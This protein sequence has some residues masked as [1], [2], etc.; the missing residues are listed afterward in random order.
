MTDFNSPVSSSSRTLE[1]LIADALEHLEQLGYSRRVYR[2]YNC[3]WKKFLCFSLT[4]D[5]DRFSS[6][7]VQSFLAD[8]GVPVEKPDIPLPQVKRYYRTAMRV[9]T[10]FHLHGCFQRRMGLAPKF[11]LSMHNEEIL[12]SYLNFC[13]DT[14][15]ISP[16]A[17]RGRKRNVTMFL[18]FL[19]TH[20]IASVGDIQPE[21]LSKFMVSQCHLVPRTLSG[22]ASD[23]RCFL[24][25]LC[26]QGFVSNNLVEQVPKIRY[27]QDA[28]IPSVWQKEDV[29]KLLTVVDRGSPTGKRDYALLLLAARLGMRV[30]DIRE[31]RLENIR[32]EESRIEIVQAKTGVPLQ[33]PLTEE[34]GGAIIDYLRHGRPLSEHREVFLRQNAPFTPFGQDNNLY[35]IIASYRQRA[36]IKLPAQCK[37]G[38]NALRH[39]LASRLLEAGT[40]LQDIANVMGHLSTETTRIYTKIDIKALR[41]VAID[42]EEAQNV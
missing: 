30:G 41:S 40:P 35:H 8:Q 42:P 23:L 28:R 25:Y 27:Q 1:R 4:Q 12:A 15:R 6:D 14:L 20:G 38:F 34:I 2:E 11:K 7:E 24:R 37:R 10:E 13:R 19:D 22:V 16:R 39:T 29:E 32:W 17:M 33:L 31:L 26:M 3:I 9:L 18:H 5:L 21:A 36:G